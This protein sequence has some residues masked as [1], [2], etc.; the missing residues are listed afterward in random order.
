M[1]PFEFSE[2]GVKPHPGVIISSNQYIEQSG[3][4]LAVLV[5]SSQKINDKYSM[6]FKTNGSLK[7][8]SQWPKLPGQ[9]RCNFIQEFSL[10]EIMPNS[11][12]DNAEMDDWAFSNLLKHLESI[13]PGQVQDFI[14]G[15]Y[16]LEY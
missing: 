16:S 2:E 7:N 1:L 5:T 6:W 3:V 8:G 14:S 15:N 4:F 11:A 13:W 10:D 12:F 9:C